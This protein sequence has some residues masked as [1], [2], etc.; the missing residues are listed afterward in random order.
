MDLLFQRMNLLLT[1]IA[2]S[3]NQTE[4]MNFVSLAIKI[5]PMNQII[6]RIK[7]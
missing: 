1:P 4:N 2:Y 7:I 5:V 3:I 6:G